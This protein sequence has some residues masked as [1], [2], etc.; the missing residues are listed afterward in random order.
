MGTT[1]H[2]FK[3]KNYVPTPM[4]LAPVLLIAALSMPATAQS[5]PTD[6]ITGLQYSRQQYG[7][8]A[9]YLRREEGPMSVEATCLTACT[10]SHG[11][12]VNPMWRACIDDARS[13]LIEYRSNL[14]SVATR[15]PP[16]DFFTYLMQLNARIQGLEQHLDKYHPPLRTAK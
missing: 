2:R 5:S 12:E 11:K 3:K 15:A 10:R 6:E 7:L 13:Q 4:R 16:A 8:M 9:I 1:P 14:L